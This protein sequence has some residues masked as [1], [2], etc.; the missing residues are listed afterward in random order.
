MIFSISVI[1]LYVAQSRRKC[2]G[3]PA[4]TLT[5]LKLQTLCILDGIGLYF[6]SSLSTCLICL[7]F[8]VCSPH[9]LR[10]QLRQPHLLLD[11]FNFFMRSCQDSLSIVV[12][13]N[14][15]QKVKRIQSQE[16]KAQRNPDALT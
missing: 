10:L 3:I 12:F 1:S 7:Q 6:Q 14:K 13:F 9:F 8:I 4:S 15:D 5:V 11:Q 2:Y 16:L